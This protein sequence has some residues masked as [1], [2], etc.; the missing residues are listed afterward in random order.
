[1]D[2]KD[3]KREPIITQALTEQQRFMPVMSLE[4]A[5]D[6]RE[7]IARAINKLMKEGHDYGKIAGD[8]D[9]LYQ[10][11]AQKLDSLFG[12]V[13]QFE[14]V[15]SDEDW[16][17][18]RHKGEPFF[19]YLTKCRLY[20]GEYLMAEAMG[21]CNSWEV[22]YRWRNTNRVCPKCGEE[23]IFKS[24]KQDEGWFCWI[25]KGGCGA[26][27][28]DNDESIISQQA[29][30]KPNPDIFDQVNTILKISLKRAHTSCTINATSASEFFTP[31]DY[32]HDGRKESPDLPYEPNPTEP[33]PTE[34]P[35][36]FNK[37]I[38]AF[39]ELR[40]AEEVKKRVLD[41]YQFNR[42]GEIRDLNLRR[43]IYKEML[44]EAKKPRV[45]TLADLAPEVQESYLEGMRVNYGMNKAQAE[46]ELALLNSAEDAI[47]HAYKQA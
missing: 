10:P 35:E 27:F 7:T 22:K 39:E 38:A 42:P 6:R 17:G 29:G 32:G 20:R 45:L 23:T 30:R 12:L 9:M 34:T 3:V 25:K 15:N 8:K 18:D 33:S 16:L 11:G 40:I 13:P 5:I 46:A 2:E 19:R 4:T 43:Q 47:R 1:M 14:I 37:S 26:K 36:E 41:R 28:A 24:K 44:D 21:E 31:D